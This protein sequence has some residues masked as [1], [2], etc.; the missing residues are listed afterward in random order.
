MGAS[1]AIMMSFFGACFAS[2]TLLLQLHW[3]GPALGLPFLGFAAIA[4]A[5]VLVVRRPGPGFARPDG[6]GRVMMWSSIGEGV[7][8]FLVNELLISL[9]RPDLILPAMALI[10]GLHFVPIA[11][12]SPFRPLYLLAAVMVAGGS[13][14]LLM[15]QPVGGAIAGFTA[16]AALAAASIAA[17]RREALAKAR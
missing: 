7:G 14:G 11:R 3:G 8:L 10:V 12:W 6:A 16:A 5:A 13:A 1:G 9:G 17:V 15:R 2:L 4:A